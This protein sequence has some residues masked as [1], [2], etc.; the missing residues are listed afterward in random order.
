MMQIDRI[1]ETRLSAPDETAIA[2][3]LTR[4]FDTDFGGRSYYQQRHHV[5]LVAR[6]GDAIVGHMALC[7]RDI[8][9]GAALVPI[10]G[11]AEVATDPQRRG[12][13]IAGRLLEAVIDEARA[14]GAVFVLLFGDRPLYA[15]HGFV[16]QPNVVTYLT[17][18]GAWT[19]AVKTGA[20]G[21]L[22]VLP[23]GNRPWDGAQPL[24]LLGH[25]F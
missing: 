14:M 18:D 15:A 6:E 21:G 2:V 1:E 13:G 9:L 23:L 12:Q 20:D 5:R 19:G 16:A 10:A 22:M 11:L 4:C 8:R 25:K 7:Y 24:D 17:L 3:L